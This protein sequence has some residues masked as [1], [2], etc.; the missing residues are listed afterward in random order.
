MFIKA[1]KGADTLTDTQKRVAQYL[2]NIEK[3]LEDKVFK[4]HLRKVHYKAVLGL[5]N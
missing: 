4:K 3:D 5:A 2:R 1:K